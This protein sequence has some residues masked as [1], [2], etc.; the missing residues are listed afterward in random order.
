MDC[1]WGSGIHEYTTMKTFKQFQ[2]DTYKFRTPKM[3]DEPTGKLYD[4]IRTLDVINKSNQE[5]RKDTGFNLPLPLAKK[6]INK[7]VKSA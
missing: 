2:E 4:T 1:S 6:K 5:F 7:K 3:Y